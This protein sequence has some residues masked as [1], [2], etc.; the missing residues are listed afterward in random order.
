M[1]ID[2]YLAYARR[3]ERRYI[4]IRQLTAKYRPDLRLGGVFTVTI[5]DARK[6]RST[7]EYAGVPGQRVK[8]LDDLGRLRPKH[9]TK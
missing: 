6:R 1:L 5:E 3:V 7:T 9:L 8:I 2:N 4:F